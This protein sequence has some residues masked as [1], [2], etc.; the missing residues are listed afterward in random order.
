LKSDLISL[1]NWKI[2]P[3]NTPALISH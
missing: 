3:V 1:Q 2:R